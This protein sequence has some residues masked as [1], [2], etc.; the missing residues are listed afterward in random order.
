MGLIR[1]AK[2]KIW[3]AVDYKLFIFDYDGNN[4]FCLEEDDSSAIITCVSNVFLSHQGIFVDSGDQVADATGP[5]QDNRIPLIAVASTRKVFLLSLMENDVYSTD[6]SV[7]VPEDEVFIC[8]H[9]FN[10]Q[11]F[12]GSKSGNI[13]EM[14][15]EREEGFFKRK[16]Y[17]KNLTRNILSYFMPTFL[18][19]S[20]GM[21]DCILKLSYDRTRNVFYSFKE[22]GL[23]E[24]Y[25]VIYEKDRA[26]LKYMCKVD[27]NNS[28]DS[29]KDERVVEIFVEEQEKKT[30]FDSVAVVAVS[31]RGR[32][33]YFKFM[34]FQLTLIN[35]RNLPSFEDSNS[36]QASSLLP[37]CIFD[38]CYY[39]NGLY[40]ASGNAQSVNRNLCLVSSLDPAKYKSNTLGELVSVY[41]EDDG[42]RV[43]DVLENEKY[44][45]FSN[46]VKY[47]VVK[48]ARREIVVLSNKSVR[49]YKKL[50][51]A[52]FFVKQLQSIKDVSGTSFSEDIVCVL[53]S[54]LCDSSD[55]E[56][57]G[58][59]GLK[60]QVLQLLSK[61]QS[62]SLEPQVSAY[63]SAIQGDINWW[64]S[65]LVYVGRLIDGVV[66]CPI[67]ELFHL[68]D[69]SAFGYV[70]VRL[71]KLEKHLVS[72]LS[73]VSSGSVGFQ[74]QRQGL[75]AQAPQQQHQQAVQAVQGLLQLV[76][77]IRDGCSFLSMVLN[78]TISMHGY[79]SNEL[80]MIASSNGMKV[81]QQADFGN[82]T[83]TEVI[84]SQMQMSL[85]DLVF[86][87]NGKE[88]IKEIGR[89][90]I[91]DIIKCGLNVDSVCS[92]LQQC[93]GEFFNSN[94]LKVYKVRPGVI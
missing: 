24:L 33:L 87:S 14:V 67:H 21:N 35:T 17:L 44:E 81:Q 69:T 65:Y 49:V 46:E 25:E 64:K 47:E 27:L 32:R 3:A 12:L 55:V 4:F 86:T 74:Q 82:T 10:G 70:I 23:L 94:D 61:F 71:D 78:G 57:L 54:L 76:K 84:T 56:S 83:L 72:V 28:V 30:K 66:T 20:Q 8:I 41:F 37:F 51:L 80:S 43:W 85:F 39:S 13:Y 73:A 5:L 45:N 50:N 16:C 52:D 38:T 90:F 59:V 40:F 62:A 77:S 89:R 92:H 42:E 60:N 34:H 31:N 48:G 63:G 22:S 9:S 1:S 53:L 6:I 15:Y 58:N 19:T 79:N 68:K 36:S 29:H 18:V 7:S 2:D 93:C 26:T 88:M 11:V 91:D 75:M